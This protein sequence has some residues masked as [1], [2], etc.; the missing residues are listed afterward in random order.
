MTKDLGPPRLSHGPTGS[1]ASPGRTG[2][3]PPSACPAPR[4]RTLCRRIKRDELE[5]ILKELE[6][7]KRSLDAAGELAG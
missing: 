1:E 6:G 7:L 5:A 3:A 2:P 4:R